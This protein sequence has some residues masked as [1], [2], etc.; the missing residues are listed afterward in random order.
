MVWGDGFPYP[1]FADKKVKFACPEPSATSIERKDIQGRPYRDLLKA[2]HARGIWRQLG[3]LIVKR[4][5]GSIGGALA[6]E[7]I[8][9][10]KGFDIE[11]CAL[12]RKQA[13]IEAYQESVF[14]VPAVMNTDIGR[15]I[16]EGEVQVVEAEARKLGRAV[17]KWRQEV[18]ADWDQKVK[19]AGKEKNALLAR[20]RSTATSHFW[21]AVEK[22]LPLL[23]A[24]TSSLDESDNEERRKAWRRAV[25]RAAREAYVLACGRESP[26]Q[27]RAFAMGLRVL[28]Y[29]E[30]PH[31][32]TQEG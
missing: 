28:E 11:V 1:A 10:N 22:N 17:V 4:R 23:L 15:A 14:H 24:Y 3:G 6:L 31:T 30:T 19:A 27:L 9:E 8:P 20:L 26:R 29:E 5:A 25:H 16:Y 2:S 18:D 13:T 7:N 12:L 21:T 32:E